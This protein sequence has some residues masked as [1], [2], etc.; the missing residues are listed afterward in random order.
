M[1]VLGVICLGIGLLMI[2][3]GAIGWVT[4]GSLA[5][6]MDQWVNPP[7]A[8]GIIGVALVAIGSWMT[9]NDPYGRR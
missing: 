1:K 4:W 6:G 7:L 8:F 2:V 5:T 3:F 9:T